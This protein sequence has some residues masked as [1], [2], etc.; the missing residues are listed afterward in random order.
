MIKMSI[1]DIK[2]VQASD[3]KIIQVLDIDEVQV[4]GKAQVIY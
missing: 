4:L 2:V 3:D 1:F